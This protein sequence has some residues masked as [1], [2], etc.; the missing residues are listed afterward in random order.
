MQTIFASARFDL[1]S[2]A[3]L[4]LA[5]AGVDID[6]EGNII[7]RD[8][9]DMPTVSFDE[10]EADLALEFYADELAEDRAED[11]MHQLCTCC[12]AG[13]PWDDEAPMNVRVGGAWYC[14]PCAQK[15]EQKLDQ[16]NRR[17]ERATVR[18]AREISHKLRT[19]VTSELQRWEIE[20]SRDDL[21]TLKGW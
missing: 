10:I 11:A 1:S 18:R 15:A 4:F 19:A 8:A 9:L 6:D 12:G 16:F 5:S 13:H 21:V 3:D 2:A 17:A 14:V 7:E 20:R